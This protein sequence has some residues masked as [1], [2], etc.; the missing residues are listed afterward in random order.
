MGF[1]V[2]IDLIFMGDKA[3]CCRAQ[4]KAFDIQFETPTV[5]YIEN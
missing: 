5:Q 1:D 2:P 3:A 4:K